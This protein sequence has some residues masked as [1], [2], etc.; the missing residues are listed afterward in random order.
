MQFD[1]KYETKRIINWIHEYFQATDFNVVIGISG[2]K[3]SSV[4]VALCVEAL[5]K[6]RVIGIML[7]NEKQDLS[8]G[9]QLAEHLG[10]EY[11]IINIGKTVQAYIDECEKSGLKISEVAKGNAIDAIRM[12]T[13]YT[14]AASENAL[15]ANTSNL[16]ENYIG[17]T[18]KFGTSRGDFSPLEDYTVTEV[19]AIGRELGLP[20]N[21]IEKIPADGLSGM[22]DEENIGFSYDILD[23][24]IREGVCED[25]EI[26]VK[27]DMMH[28]NSR[29][30][31]FLPKLDRNE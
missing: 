3:D 21:L 10:I 17:Y 18:T 9:L 25:S 23:R 12:A 14:V 26:K 2:G 11:K 20:E 6:D 28:K 7:P 4:V 29:H 31:F 1:A 16:S 19:K 24:Y 8:D 27:I 15:V 22:T 5:D 30:K 13:L